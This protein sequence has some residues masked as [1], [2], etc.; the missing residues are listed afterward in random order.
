MRSPRAYSLHLHFPLRYYASR[1]SGRLHSIPILRFGRISSLRQTP[2]PLPHLKITWTARETSPRSAK[3][4]RGMGF[5]HSR[6]CF[7]LANSYANGA[8]AFALCVLVNDNVYARTAHW[9]YTLRCVVQ[10]Y[11][12]VHHIIWSRMIGGCV[13]KPRTTRKANR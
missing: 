8:F 12:H 7:T 1:V 13:I 5:T 2:L 6:A 3:H 9:A 10:R 4:A 11:V